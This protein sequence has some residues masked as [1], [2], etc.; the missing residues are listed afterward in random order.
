MVEEDVAGSRDGVDS[1][2]GAVGEEFSFLGTVPPAAELFGVVGY[3]V[4]FAFDFLVEGDV[5]LSGGDAVDDGFEG[6]AGVVDGGDDTVNVG[7]VGVVS[8]FGN[9]L[10]RYGLWGDGGRDHCEDIAG[11]DVEYDGCGVE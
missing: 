8:V 5:E 2:E 11:V 10:S 3:E 4:A 6:R 7:A 9:F 1:V